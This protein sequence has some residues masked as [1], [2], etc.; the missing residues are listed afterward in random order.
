FSTPK[1]STFLPRPRE[2]EQ[3]PV[4]C[5][6]MV[7]RWQ[8]SSEHQAE[9]KIETSEEFLTR[10]RIWRSFW[11]AAYPAAVGWPTP[12]PP[13]KHPERKAAEYARTPNASR[14]PPR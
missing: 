4:S 14:L 7:S 1:L 6:F 5:V 12:H 3:A 10:L 8:G 9:T 2:L 13:T 11:S